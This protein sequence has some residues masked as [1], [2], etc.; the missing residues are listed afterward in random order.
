MI[1]FQGMN[2]EVAM[3]LAYWLYIECKN[4]RT[5]ILFKEIPRPMPDDDLR[6]AAVHLVCPSCGFE[7]I[8]LPPEIHLGIVDLEE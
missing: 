7:S 8:Y 4:C 5:E 2:N 6:S 3:G 1:A